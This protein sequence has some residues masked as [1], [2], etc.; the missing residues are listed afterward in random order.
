M[1]PRPAALDLPHA[2]AERVTLPIVTHEGDHRCTLSPH[3]RALA[4]QCTCTALT[5]P[6]SSRPGPAS[7]VGTA[8]AYGS[9]V[10]TLL[11]ARAP[12]P[13]AGFYGRRPL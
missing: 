10:I 3:Q 6:Q 12:G 9:A 8:H 13:W 4:A 5:R 1:V 11:A 7:P 2:L